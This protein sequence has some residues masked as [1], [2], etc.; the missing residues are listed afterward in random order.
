MSQISSNILQ[1][2][3]VTSLSTSNALYDIVACACVE[4]KISNFLTTKC[5]ILFFRLSFFCFSHLFAAVT[6]LLLG[7]L[8]VKRFLRKH[9]RDGNFKKK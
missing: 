2:A 3:L 9:H 5:I 7:L 6:D 8:S 4:I 1:K